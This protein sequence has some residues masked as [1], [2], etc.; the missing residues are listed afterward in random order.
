MN[1]HRWV[2]VTACD[3]IPPREGRGIEV[4][5]R[6]VAIFNLGDR[7][8][9]SD[10]RCP[11]KSGP[12]CEGILNGS[13]VV[14]PLHGWK[15]DLETGAVRRPAGVDACI[16]TYPTRVQNGIVMIQLPAG[17]GCE[18]ADGRAA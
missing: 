10:S 7:F 18:K 13:T 15:I 1:E 6:E 11:H 4:A 17:T 14:C 8:L 12:L 9:A 5:G 16:R 2:P 3:N